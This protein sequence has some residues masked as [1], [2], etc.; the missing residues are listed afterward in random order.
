[1]EGSYADT[2]KETIFL[3]RVVQEGANST[4]CINKFIR[5]R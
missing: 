5:Q 1:M 2:L 4:G 3:G